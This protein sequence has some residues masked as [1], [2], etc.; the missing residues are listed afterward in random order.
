MARVLL[1]SSLAGVRKRLTRVSPNDA[2]HHAT[3]VCGWEGVD[4][5]PDGGDWESAIGHARRQ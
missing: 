5:R 2:V 4:I 3:K 1:S